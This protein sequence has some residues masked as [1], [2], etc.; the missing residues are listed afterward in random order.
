MTFFLI[1]WAVPNFVG[2]ETY[3][4][5]KVL[6]RKKKLQN[7]RHTC[8]Q[9]NVYSECEKPKK[10][11]LQK[12]CQI[13][14]T[15]KKKF[16]FFKNW[17]FSNFLYIFWLQ[18]FGQ[19]SHENPF[20]RFSWGKR[21]IVGFWAGTHGFVSVC[22]SLS[23]AS[24]CPDAGLV[25][26]VGGRS[27]LKAVHVPDSSQT[28]TRKWLQ[29]ANSISRNLNLNSSF[30]SILKCPQLLQLP[31]ARWS[32][33]DWKRPCLHQTWTETISFVF[34]KSI[35]HVKEPK[36]RNSPRTLET[37]HKERALKA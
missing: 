11:Q 23:S 35:C 5:V 6:C 25:C 9:M 8:I 22:L 27:V 15:F 33:L 7:S 31:D 30:R 26:T 16:L 20:L 32:E 28:L 10:L 13:P 3:T 21:M 4:I 14:Q 2:F 12:S 17:H 18:F 37:S 19:S 34:Y 1:K 24:L 36:A 29:T